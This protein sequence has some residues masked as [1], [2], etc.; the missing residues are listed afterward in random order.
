MC[1]LEGKGKSNFGRRN[2]RY[3]FD[4]RMSW[5]F[6]I[7]TNTKPYDTPHINSNDL[8]MCDVCVCVCIIWLICVRVFSVD[9]HDASTKFFFSLHPHETKPM[10]IDNRNHIARK[11]PFDFDA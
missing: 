4:E 7:D 8:H 3:P 11:N 6:A 10:R 1:G 9:T 2:P 5:G